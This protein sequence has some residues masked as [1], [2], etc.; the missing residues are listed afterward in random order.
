MVG[1]V[2]G[3]GKGVG[4]FEGVGDSCQVLSSYRNASC[5]GGGR[6][7]GGRKLCIWTDLVLP[8]DVLDDGRD[9]GVVVLLP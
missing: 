6:E 1:F 8:A 9:G 2:G 4:W 7:D 3:G 5:T